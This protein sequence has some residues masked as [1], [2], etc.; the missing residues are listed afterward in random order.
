MRSQLDAL[1][2]GGAMLSVG[3]VGGFVDSDVDAS[4]ESRQPSR[5]RG[6]KEADH[7]TARDAP[8]ASK[9]S[10]IRGHSEAS[11]DG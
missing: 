10:S 8:K 7:Q 3:G 2:K 6:R 1:V 4:D 9:L 5:D 11:G